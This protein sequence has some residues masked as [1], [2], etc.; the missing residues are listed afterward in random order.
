MVRWS[1]DTRLPP[2]RRGG[3]FDR[4]RYVTPERTWDQMRVAYHA[5]ETDDV[6]SGVLESTEAR[7]VDQAVDGRA[8]R[9]GRG[10]A[11]DAGG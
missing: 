11:K 2:S 4:D 7:P 9:A 3:L 5:A 6:V 8:V 10:G 1:N